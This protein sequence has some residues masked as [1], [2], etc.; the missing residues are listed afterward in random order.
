[1]VK[2]VKFGGS[3]LADARQFKKVADIVKSDSSR[4]FVI[5]SAPGK[6]FDGDTK[7]TDMLY[8]CYSKAARGQDFEKEF[9]EIKERYNGIIEELSL[10]VSL[11]EEFNTIKACFS[12]KQEGIMRRQ[13]ANI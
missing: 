11:E 10:D 13:E 5:P 6:R 7:I 2:V 1:M 8:S 12:Q 3:S 9:D 4:K